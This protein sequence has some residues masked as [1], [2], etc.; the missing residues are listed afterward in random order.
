[1]GT[2]ERIAAGVLVKMAMDEIE[3]VWWAGRSWLDF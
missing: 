2:S 3:I 1:M